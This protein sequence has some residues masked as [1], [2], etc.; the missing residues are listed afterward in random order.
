MTRHILIIEQDHQQKIKVQEVVTHQ[1]KDPIKLHHCPNYEEAFG[2]VFL[3]KWDLVL[4]NLET[5]RDR[6]LEMLEKVLTLLELEKTPTVVYDRQT[7]Q[8]NMAKAVLNKVSQYLFFRDD[9][10]ETTGWQPIKGSLS[11]RSAE[12]HNA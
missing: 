1:I 4:I 5:I 6:S 3:K 2:L 12:T 10:A 8:L 11:E 7:D 9:V